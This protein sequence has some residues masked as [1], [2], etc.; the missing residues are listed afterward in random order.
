MG[1]VGS[2]S[3]ANTFT[4]LVS[5]HPDYGIAA[6]EYRHAISPHDFLSA[7]YTLGPTFTVTHAIVRPLESPIG[8]SVGP[9]RVSSRMLASNLS[10]S[11]IKRSQELRTKVR[12]LYPPWACAL[13]AWTHLV[14]APNHS[15][16]THTDLGPYPF[17]R[18]R[19]LVLASK[20]LPLVE[21]HITTI[22]A[23]VAVNHIYLP[24]L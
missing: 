4:D 10:H 23:A 19:S 17:E 22:E 5:V 2:P 15:Y 3:L 21:K 1:G 12:T 14:E 7:L 16:I 11:L 18:I 20:I 8:I 9:L 6:T 24:C 13:T